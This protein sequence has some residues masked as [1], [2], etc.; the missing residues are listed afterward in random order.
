[1]LAKDLILHAEVLDDVLLV[2]IHPESRDVERRT[3][4]IKRN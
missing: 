1:M 3:N 2:S 4:V